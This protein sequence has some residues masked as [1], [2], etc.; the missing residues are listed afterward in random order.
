MPRRGTVKVGTVVYLYRDV[1]RQTRMSFTIGNSQ[2]LI[3]VAILQAWCHG[4]IKSTPESAPIDTCVNEAA[5]Q[6]VIAAGQ[7][8]I[9]PLRR[10][11]NFDIIDYRVAF[12]LT[13]AWNICNL[14][15]AE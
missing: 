2:K 3:S 7:V 1:G 8:P 14:S 12:L 6:Q 9:T 11:S 13:N 15:A 5:R 4:L 10:W